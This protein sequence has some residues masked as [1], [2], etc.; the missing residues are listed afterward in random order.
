MSNQNISRAYVRAISE[1]TEGLDLNLSSELT[2]VWEVINSS[3]DLENLLFFDV[4]TL[5]ERYEAFD[6]ILKKINVHDV[7]SNFLLFLVNE[8]RIHL[9]PLIYKELIISEDL[10]KG[11]ISGTIEGS[12]S[13]INE[14]MFDKIKSYLEDKLNIKTKLTYQKNDKIS[15]GYKVTAG[16]LQLDATLENQLKNFKNDILHN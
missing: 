15:A 3:N 13:D 2:K 14:A 6:A 8:K 10:K 7:V 11:F 9:L 5:E 1:I 12:D 4:F 16:D